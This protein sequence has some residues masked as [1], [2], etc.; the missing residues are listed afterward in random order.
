MLQASANAAWSAEKLI[1]RYRED[2]FNGNIDKQ[3]LERHL[4]VAQ[5][6]ISTARNT[7]SFHFVTLQRSSAEQEQQAEQAK[8]E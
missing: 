5:T 6:A 4:N 8:G 1:E 7:L 3:E 2:I